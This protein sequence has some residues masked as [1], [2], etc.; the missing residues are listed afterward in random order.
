MVKVRRRLVVQ[1]FMRT[2]V[3]EHVAKAIE[4]ALL[5]AKGRCGRI[6]RIFL[7]RS[8]HPL[9]TTVLL[10]AAWLNAFVDDP[11]FIQP[12]ESFDSPSSPV[13]AKGAPLSV[14]MRAGIPYS[15][16]AASQIALT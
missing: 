9:V 5:R 6:Q 8:V 14:L 10:W 12:S 4:S 16:M 11:S 1:A 13:P 7:E 15:R 2:L 3:V